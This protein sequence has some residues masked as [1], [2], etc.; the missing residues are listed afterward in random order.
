M[1]TSRKGDRE[2]YSAA[3][4][5]KQKEKLEIKV[6]QERVSEQNYRYLRT[7]KLAAHTTV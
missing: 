7:D 6:Q 2:I 4:A 3:R 1:K 5:N